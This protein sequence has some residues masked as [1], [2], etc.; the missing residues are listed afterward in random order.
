MTDDNEEKTQVEII[1]RSEDVHELPDGTKKTYVIVSYV[2]PRGSGR[3]YVDKDVYDR[4]KE[5]EYI[6]ADLAKKVSEL[7]HESLEV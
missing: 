1:R 7:V 2:S 6:K 4:D 3:V 5:G